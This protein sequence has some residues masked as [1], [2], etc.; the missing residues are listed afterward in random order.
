MNRQI[1]LTEV[2]TRDGFQIEPGFI[3]TE[4]KID[5]IKRLIKTGIKRI[6]VTSF[7]HPKYVPQMR[8]A[9][10]VFQGIAE[11]KPSDVKFISLALNERGIERAVAARTD[12]INFAFSASEAHNM[13]NTQR[14]VAESLKNIKTLVKSAERENVSVN[15]GIATSFGCP[16]EGM[17]Q[18]EKVLNVVQKVIDMGISSVIL[19]D[20]TGMAHPKQVRET[21]QQVLDQFPQLNLQLHL[22]N[23]RGMG[24]ANLL[25]GIDAGVTQFD[26][27]VAGI[28][29]CPFAPNASGNICTED[30]VHMLHLMGYETNINIDPLLLIARELEIKLG[31]ALP[32]QVMKAGKSTDLHSADW[33]PA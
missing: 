31:R 8:D 7:V 22:H 4:Y 13:K 3:E 33:Q 5:I 32:G 29:G 27:S 12:E 26:S 15:V 1:S 2:V 19:A 24:A 6:E 16:F 18:P 14:T 28:G 30:I 9:E 11:D 21:C 20:T 17:Y 10:A 23:T 25:A